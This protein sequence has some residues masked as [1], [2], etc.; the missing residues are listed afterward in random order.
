MGIYVDASAGDAFTAGGGSLLLIQGRDYQ[1]TNTY[2][3]SYWKSASGKLF[4]R[5]GR[6]TNQYTI[7]GLY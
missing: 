5:K 1:Y 2:I 6:G 4:A 7:Q 3:I